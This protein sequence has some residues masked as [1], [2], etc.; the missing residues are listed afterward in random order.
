MSLKG[1]YLKMPGFVQNCFCTAHGIRAWRLR[2]TG[3]FKE[4]LRW[5]EQTDTWTLDR[6]TDYQNEKLRNIVSLAYKQVPFWKSRFDQIG[7]RPEDIRTVDDLKHFPILTK[8]EVLE[9]GEKAYNRKYKTGELF[10]SRT[11]GSTGTP[12][13]LVATK[14]CV[15]FQ[16]ALWW[17]HLSVG[18]LRG[19]VF[20]VRRS[21]DK[22]D[23]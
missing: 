4:Y 13:N 21:I 1:L 9:A 23:T 15:K 16:W 7:I 5:L 2:Y 6:L 17:R 14:N 3:K 10:V 12:L 18:H 11:S 8:A 19:L 20:A 22:A